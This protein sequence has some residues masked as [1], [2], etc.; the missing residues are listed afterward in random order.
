MND[1]DLVTVLGNLSQSLESVT[2]L[3]GGVSYLAGIILF[4]S[5]LMKL[6]QAYGSVGQSHESP[7]KAVAFI[8]TAAALFFLPTTIHMVSST[9]FGATSVLQYAQVNKGDVFQSVVIIIQTAGLIWFIRGCI[10]VL[11]ANKSSGEEEGT[12]G[13]FFLCA[14]VMA[15]NFSLTMGAVS[16]IVNQLL[17]LTFFA[18]KT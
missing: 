7:F 10:M 12:R 15:I 8:M 11:H 4:F 16:Y 14:G 13:F 2:Y 1:T 18:W 3:I 6:K 17:S 5:G 9:I